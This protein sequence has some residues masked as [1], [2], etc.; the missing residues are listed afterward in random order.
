MT[1]A[2]PVTPGVPDL[3]EQHRDHR[4]RPPRPEDQRVHPVGARVDDPAH[5]REDRTDGHERP[6][7]GPV[8]EPCRDRLVRGQEQTAE[9]EAVE[10]R[11]RRVE[12]LGCGG[13]GRGSE[14]DEHRWFA[15]GEVPVDVGGEGVV[16]A[17]PV[18]E[19][20]ERIVVAPVRRRREG[21]RRDECEVAARSEPVVEDVPVVG[22][23][24]VPRPRR[25]EVPL[26]E[27]P[28]RRAR[29]TSRG[30]R[31]ARAPRRPGRRAARHPGTRWRTERRGSRAQLSVTETRV[32]TGKAQ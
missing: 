8:A 31:D 9:P 5:A 10:R 4:R 23:E 19:P 16:V 32:T 13:R 27:R 14:T 30:G 28:S 21:A 3:V 18:G 25:D 11:G 7:A 12:H 20:D 22:G 1:S 24:P 15:V 26:R 2:A 29:G 17:R 6:D